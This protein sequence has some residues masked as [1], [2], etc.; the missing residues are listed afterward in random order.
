M[1]TVFSKTF[2]YSKNQKRSIFPQVSDYP[3]FPTCI[4]ATIKLHREV[5]NV[6][7]HPNNQICF[8]YISSSNLR[9]VSLITFSLLRSD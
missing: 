4:Y 1:Q 6:C 9:V 3:T 8:K 2:L 5:K 7:L